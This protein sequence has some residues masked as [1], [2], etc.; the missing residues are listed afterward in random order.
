MSPSFHQFMKHLEKDEEGSHKVSLSDL[1]SF[2]KTWTSKT[3]H[4]NALFDLLVVH[5]GTPMQ[6]GKTSP[7]E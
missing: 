1:M 4:P 6:G 3:I 5:L 7:P 2:Y